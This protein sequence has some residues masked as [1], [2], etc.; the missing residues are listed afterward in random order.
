MRGWR[1]LA[2][3]WLGL[4][5]AGCATGPSLRESR[6]ELS[7][8]VAEGQ[9]SSKDLAVQEAL[10]N[11]IQQELG[12]YVQ[13]DTLVRQARLIDHEVLAYS[14]GYVESYEV[15]SASEDQSKL[16]SAT[17]F[18]G[19]R[20]E[21]LQ[22]RLKSLGV[23][24]VDGERESMNASLERD[25]RKTAVRLVEWVSEALLKKQWKVS[26]ADDFTHEPTPDGRVRIHVTVRVEGDKRE[27]GRALSP[28]VKIALPRPRD[29]QILGL[30][31]VAVQWVDVVR[32][33]RVSHERPI[34]VQR[35]ASTAFDGFPVWLPL[36]SVNRMKEIMR[37]PV[38]RVTVLDGARRHVAEGRWKVSSQNQEWEPL[39]LVHWRESGATAFVTLGGLCRPSEYSVTGTCT[40]EE[41]KRVKHI[42]AVMELNADESATR[43]YRPFEIVFG[44]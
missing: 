1:A 23:L 8:G 16:Y 33:D 21:S 32:E 24:A 17:V 22:R 9:G 27:W 34:V 10:K 20:R 30:Q 6:N 7:W 31:Q 29:E 43:R 25:Q 35:W 36:E 18:G 13:S 5:L 44:N 11:L 2:A 42:E 15:L 41:L 26:V 19:V 39:N 14:R 38:L 37:S 40:V 12:V 28:L 3:G 4:M